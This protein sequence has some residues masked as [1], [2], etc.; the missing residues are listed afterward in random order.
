[1]D[2]LRSRLVA[3][4]DGL[5]DLAW[6]VIFVDDGSADGSTA[7]LE[8]ACV[9]DP[10]LTMLVLSRNFGHMGALL[11]GLDHADAHAVVL[12]DGD[13]QDP[14]ELIPELVAAWRGG[15]EVVR[16]ERSSRA[17]GG[18]RGPAIALFHY[19]YG[20]MAD[21]GWP[22][23]VGTFS[24]LDRRAA[25]ALRTLREP[26]AFLPG[27]RDWIGFRQTAV[28][29]RRDARFQGVPKQSARRLVRY[30]ADAVFGHSRTP[31]RLV[32]VVAVAC[33][34]A[35]VVLLALGERTIGAFAFFTALQVTCIGL[36][37]G[38]VTRTLDQVRGRPRYLVRARVGVRE[39]PRA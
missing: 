30:A 37:G 38:Y 11:A 14:P 15:A 1:V 32:T 21:E 16:A 23:D 20:W 22:T 17:E 35:S 5:T 39:P 19:A 18:W 12:M 27:L 6:R 4:L 10:R 24:L 36:V 26:A 25:E 3:S 31:I 2:A 7:L 34:S 8:A 28:P 9:A 29:Y 33:F 13:L